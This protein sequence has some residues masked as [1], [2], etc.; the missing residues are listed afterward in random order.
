[1]P[2]KPAAMTPTPAENRKKMAKMEAIATKFGSWRQA[3]DVLIKVA[4]VPTRF[5]GVDAVTGI[6]GWPIQRICVVHGP[7]NEGKT[8]LCIGLM[9][10]FLQLGH[11]AAFI[12]AEQTTPAEWI[13]QLMGA[14]RLSPKFLA[15]RPS[16]YEEAVYSTRQLALGIEAERKG[17]PGLSG[18]VVVDSI[19][20]LTPKGLLDKLMKASGDE[21]KPRGRFG[22]GPAGIDGANGRAAQ[23]KAAIN[24]QWLDELV[25]L[26]VRGNLSI[27]IVARELADDDDPFT[28]PKVAGGAALNYDASLRARVTRA[29]ALMVDGDDPKKKQYIGER[30]AVSIQKSKIAAKEERVPTGYFHTSNGT[31]EGTT[32]GFDQPRDVFETALAEG[33]V[34]KSGAWYAFGKKRLGQGDENAIRRVRREPELLAEIETALRAGFKLEGQPVADAG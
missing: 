24:A 6:G 27:V 30:H 8:A 21:E 2:R 1:M 12:D 17:N 7:S 11:Y 32:V 14:R 5:P 13:E 10:S 26:A 34:Q 31:L 15:M 23:Q 29:A 22:K 16:N 9:D 20:K 19:R 4:G 3:S 25:P 33:V 28:L 18:I